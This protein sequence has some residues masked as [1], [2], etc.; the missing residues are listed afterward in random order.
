ML[1]MGIDP[2]TVLGWAIGR[3]GEIPR[4]GSVRLKTPSQDRDIAP[5]NALCFLRDTW[6]LDKPDLVC[7]EHF[8][9][10]AAQKSAD[11]II[12]QIEVY[13]VIVAMCRAYG[14]RYEAPQRMTVLKHFIGVGRTG[15]RAETKRAVVQRAIMLGYMPRG[16]TDD[17]RADACAVFDWSAAHHGRTPPRSLALFGERAEAP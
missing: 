10:P 2:A 7:V 14:I 6:I 1:I 17:N 12:L 4:S 13:G 15:D 11:A 5:F 8:M 3:A 16:C 9:N